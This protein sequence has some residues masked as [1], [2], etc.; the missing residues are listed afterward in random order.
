MRLTTV[1][2]SGPLPPGVGAST[3]RRRRRRRLRRSGHVTPTSPCTGGIT[4]VSRCPFGAHPDHRSPLMS[5][6]VPFAFLVHPRARI[7]EDLARVWRPLGRLP[8]GLLDSAVRRLP[9]PSYAMARV[10]LDS[11]PVG[12]VVLVPFGAKHLLSEPHEG[13][14]R[15]GRAIDHA[16]RLGAGVVGL[17]ALTATVTAGGATLRRRTDIGVTNGNAYT[18]AIV[19]DQ[20]V[21]PARGPVGPPGRRRRCHRLRRH[22]A[23]P[24]ARAVRRRSTRSCWSP[25]ACRSSTRSR[26][27]WGAGCRRPRRRTCTTC[28]AATP[29]S[30]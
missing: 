18:A 4:S 19:E 12:H 1:P 2:T 20:L 29:W 8:E 13:R 28:A 26:R 23:G 9:L 27:R 25:A 7:A 10:H 17:G 21:G 5:S 30:C 24:P 16:A 11:A 22:H 6:A 14:A 15:V 3:F